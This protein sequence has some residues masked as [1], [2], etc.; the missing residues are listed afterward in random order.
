MNNEI[1]D[2][3]E[4]LFSPTY[5]Y[6]TYFCL[7][8]LIANLSFHIDFYIFTYLVWDN[9]FQISFEDSKSII[10]LLLIGFYIISSLSYVVAIYGIS[11][12]A[13]YLKNFVN[14]LF[15]PK[16]NKDNNYQDIIVLN[17]STFKEDPPT[18]QPSTFVKLLISAEFDDL[19]DPPYNIEINLSFLS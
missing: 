15:N 8:L 1:T 13:V 12:S 11:I 2:L 16:K 14:D 17:S 3:K 10:K 9:L 19:T 7:I 4:F 18:K 6:V 5:K